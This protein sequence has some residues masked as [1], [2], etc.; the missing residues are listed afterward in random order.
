MFRRVALTAVVVTA[1]LVL[2]RAQSPGRVLTTYEDLVNT[3]F[4]PPV[5]SNGRLEVSQIPLPK[6]EG[7]YAI[8]GSTGRDHRGHI[9]FGVSSYGS[10]PNSAHLIE[11]IPEQSQVI[12]RGDVV[13]ELKRTGVYRPGEAQMK[14]HSKIV[15]AGDG[16]LYFSSSDEEG[17]EEDGT[18]LPRWGSHLWRYR[19]RDNR[20]EHLAAVPEGV[21][22]MSGI[23]MR[24][25][26]LGYF[27]HV[28]YQLDCATGKTRS[29]RVGSVDGHISR[30]LLSDE[31]GHA[32]VPRMTSRLGEVSVSL[33]EF[34]A[35]LQQ[36]GETPLRH[37]LDR[38]QPPVDV[39]GIVGLQYLA[40][41]SIVFLTHVGYLY[42]IVPH[43]DRQ[44]D[45]SE[46]GWFHPGGEA[47]VASLFTLDG[48]RY[49]AGVSNREGAYQW[50]VYDLQ[51]KKGV[52]HPLDLP[53]GVRDGAL[54]GSLTRDNAGSFYAVG[55]YPIEPEKSAPVVLQMRYRSPT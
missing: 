51:T 18:R 54:Y 26:A 41:K 30:N 53:P 39:H 49:L 40:D 42:R 38:G 12:N 31:H 6:L 29:V 32:Y 36:I 33:V 8:W 19:L 37:Y 28:L 10:K 5:D 20:W 9:W 17:E 52:A 47:Y 7:A 1:T 35:A 21:I 45:V 4:G 27:D 16:N 14:I 43:E 25:Y 34:N 15:E 2:A 44:A 48:S 11:F 22:A 23:G 50:V 3:R 55:T 13:S 46:V 24:M